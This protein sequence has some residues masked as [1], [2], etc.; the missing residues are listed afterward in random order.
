MLAIL[1]ALGTRV[2]P[3]IGIRLLVA[4][5]AALALA[6]CAVEPTA[7]GATNLLDSFEPTWTTASWTG[8]AKGPPNDRRDEE[9]TQWKGRICPASSVILQNHTQEFAG[10][11]IINNCT[12][13]VTYAL[14]VTKGSLP[15]PQS[16]LQPCATD[17]FD[18]P[19]SR[20]TFKTINPGQLGDFINA[21]QNLSI[22]LF[23]CSDEM[24]LTAPPVRC[25]G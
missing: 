18:T 9:A 16:G 14:C 21:T 25:I 2:G 12:I 1:Q 23:F 7:P 5:F 13:T 11:H 10:L 6:A 19:F 8:G 22:Q 15:Q 17:P 4:S 20:L 24:Q 3:F